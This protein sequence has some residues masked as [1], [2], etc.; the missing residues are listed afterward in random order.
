MMKTLNVAALA[1][2]TM[3]TATPALA[4]NSQELRGSIC[5][6]DTSV[7][8]LN[9]PYKRDDTSSIFTFNSTKLCTGVA[10]KRNIKLVCT[11]D[12]KPEWGARP[13]RTA[14]KFPCTINPDQCGLEPKAGDTANPPYVTTRDSTLK[15]RGGVAELICHY[16]P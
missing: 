9:P 7:L 8:N 4:Q 5:E 15:V 6:I 12:L 13:D 2:L 10:S 11:A 3:C 1:F 16:K 14:Q